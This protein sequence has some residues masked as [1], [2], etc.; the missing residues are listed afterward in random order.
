MIVKSL[1]LAPPSNTGSES[2]FP[3]SFFSSPLS[4]DLCAA[5][6]CL[7]SSEVKVFASSLAFCSSSAAFLESAAR[8]FSAQFWR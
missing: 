7:L 3:L 2:V 8:C 5:A 6:N 1:T 4:E